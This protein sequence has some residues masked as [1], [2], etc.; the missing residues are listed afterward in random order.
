MLSM[1]LIYLIKKTATSRVPLM[2]VAIY[3]PD[4]LQAHTTERLFK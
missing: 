2:T 3:L 1:S 4:D